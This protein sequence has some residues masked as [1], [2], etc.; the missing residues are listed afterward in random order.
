MFSGRARISVKHTGLDLFWLNQRLKPF[1]VILSFY[2]QTL[3]ATFYLILLHLSTQILKLQIHSFKR[4][5][6]TC[7]C[8][9]LYKLWKLIELGIFLILW[10]LKFTRVWTFYDGKKA[11][12]FTANVFTKHKI[13]LS[14]PNKT[15]SYEVVQLQFWFILWE[16]IRYFIIFFR[17]FSKS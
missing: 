1:C 2:Q 3:S 10:E 17:Y 5:R 15:A 13:I 9:N 4:L 8:N 11:P 16:S 12:F 14:G 6:C 7:K